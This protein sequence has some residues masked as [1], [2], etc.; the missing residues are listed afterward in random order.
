MWG[1]ILGLPGT[2]RTRFGVLFHPAEAAGEDG[3][4]DVPVT[5]IVF[6]ARRGSNAGA[7]R[8]EAL[9]AGRALLALAPYSSRRERGIGHALSALQ[10]L[11]HRVPA[12]DLGRGPLADM[13]ARVEEVTRA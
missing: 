5:A 11:A 2:T 10:P 9:D 7:G 1:R 12:F 6:L 4:S 3:P 8:I 13:V